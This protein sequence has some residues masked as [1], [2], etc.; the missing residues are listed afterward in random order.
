MQ[1]G[2]A[3]GKNNFLLPKHQCIFAISI[4]PNAESYCARHVLKT[5]DTYFSTQDDAAP[6]PADSVSEG[7]APNSSQQDLFH[8]DDFN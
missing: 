4:T 7:P 1:D 6:P 8:Q 5:K 3:C 2:Y